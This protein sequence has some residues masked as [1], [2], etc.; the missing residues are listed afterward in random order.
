LWR[1]LGSEDAFDAEISA[2]AITHDL[3]RLENLQSFPAESPQLIEGC[4]WTPDK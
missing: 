4:I 2:L 1:W 3:Y